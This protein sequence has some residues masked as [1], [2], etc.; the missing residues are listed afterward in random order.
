MHVFERPVRFADVDATGVV[1][2]PTFFAYCSEALEQ[3]LLL[4]IRDGYAEVVLQRKIG[5]P[6]VRIAGDFT[7]PLRFGDTARIAIQTEH[8]GT[9]SFTL[10]Y[11]VTRA[12]DGLPVAELRGTVA[13]IDLLS[14]RPIHIPEDIRSV[15]EQHRS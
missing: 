15:L 10:R 2:F 6:T 14:T 7:S 4:V 9:R 11:S 5:L 13:T 8:I 1:F 12:S 3:L